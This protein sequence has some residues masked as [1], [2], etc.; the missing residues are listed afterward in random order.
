M[1]LLTKQTQKDLG[2]YTSVVNN[3]VN[4]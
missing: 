4:G 3:T 2:K 1:L